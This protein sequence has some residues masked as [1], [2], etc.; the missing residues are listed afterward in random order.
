MATTPAIPT[1]DPLTG[2][3]AEGTIRGMVATIARE[4]RPLAVILFGSRARGDHRPTSDVD[5]LVVLPAIPADV[6]RRQVRAALYDRLSGA[7]LPKDILVATPTQLAE[8]RGDYSS[9]L[10]HAQEEGVALY[11][12]DGAADPIAAAEMSKAPG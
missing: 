3:P 4:A 1:R 9:V 2:D 8:A 11:R 12:A 5:L 6:T 7:G 10:H